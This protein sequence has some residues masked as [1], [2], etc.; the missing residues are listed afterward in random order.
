MV[1][2][3]VTGGV[4]QTL[5]RSVFAALVP[6]LLGRSVRPDVAVDELQQ[7]IPTRF[8][9][10]YSS[11]LMEMVVDRC[12]SATGAGVPSAPLSLTL[13]PAGGDPVGPLPLRAVDEHLF[14]TTLEGRPYSVAFEL[15]DDGRAVAALAGLRRLVRRR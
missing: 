2:L 3:L 7:V 10:T 4:P 1:A 9:G 15:G 12:E 11:P 8:T 13:R 6:A 14:L 5:H